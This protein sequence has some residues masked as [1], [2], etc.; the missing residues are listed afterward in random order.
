M[1]TFFC[2]QS[3]LAATFVFAAVLAFSV[4]QLRADTQLFTNGGYDTGADSGY[5]I[6]GT[7]GVT[8][9]F[10]VSPAGTY[11]LTT[12]TV[13]LSPT[14]DN[15]PPTSISWS[16]GTSKFGSQIGSG[17]ASGTQLSYGT[18]QLAHPATSHTMCTTFD[19]SATLPVSSGTT[20]YL[21][22]TS[23][24]PNNEF[25]WEESADASTAY[26][27]NSSS[28]SPAAYGEAFSINGVSAVPEPGS[29]IALVGLGAMGLVGCV[30]RQRR[31]KA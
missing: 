30:W 12:A 3:A 15:N 20:Y 10:T 7:N 19:F 29:F 4:T 24:A 31:V 26:Y 5:N 28:S 17:T 8:D 22:L 18:L 2:R 21:T 27:G 9:A 23:A 1:S 25:S 14:V 6:G 13:Y 16:V 11:N